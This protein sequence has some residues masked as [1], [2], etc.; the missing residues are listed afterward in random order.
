M[1]EQI[2]S[3]GGAEYLVAHDKVR[4]EMYAAANEVQRRTFHRRALE[5]LR[6]NDTVPA[7]RRAY[8]AMRAGLSDEA[9]HWNIAAGAKPAAIICDDEA[10]LP[11]LLPGAGPTS[12][13]PRA[14]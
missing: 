12:A 14:A 11:P 9:A 13:G 7:A 8:H 3:D 10:T 2:G 1:H 5:S 6:A 4:D